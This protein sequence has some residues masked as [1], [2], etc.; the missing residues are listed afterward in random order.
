M[1]KVKE[2]LQGEMMRFSN[3]R[4]NEPERCNEVCAVG[5]ASRLRTRLRTPPH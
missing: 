4:K 5:V 3:L 1:L 2:S